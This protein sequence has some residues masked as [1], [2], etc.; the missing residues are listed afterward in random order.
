MTRRWI[1]RSIFTLP[2]LLCLAGW[3]WSVDH[4]AW[5]GGR[6]TTHYIFVGT[7]GGR[8]FIN[9]GRDS[10]APAHFFA[11][12][13]PRPR[14]FWPTYG[15]I[16]P[17]LLGFDTYHDSTPSMD[18]RVLG[19]AYWALLILAGVL[20]FFAWRQTRLTRKAFQVEVVA[21]TAAG[22]AAPRVSITADTSTDHPPP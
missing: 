9:A 2:L 5:F 13:L 4:D 14:E 8:I 22:A 3:G 12:S 16:H 18:Y 7:Y 17:H 19:M 10:S 1:I 20:M 21:P 11:E 6:S 15:K